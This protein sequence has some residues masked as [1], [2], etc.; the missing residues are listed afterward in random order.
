[1]KKFINQLISK[2]GYN[3]TKISQNQYN[4]F[5]TEFFSILKIAR[6]FSMTSPERMYAAYQATKYIV[7]NNISGDIVECGTWRGGS[8]MIVALTLKLLKSTERK[9]YLYDTY[10]GMSQPT[11]KDVSINQMSAFKNWAK[12][13]NRKEKVFCY[14]P[15]EEV[16]QNVFSTGYPVNN[17]IFVKGKVE[18]TIPS[19][20]PNQIALL[21]L[22]TDWYES[23][24]HEMKHLYPKLISDGVLIIDD[25]GHWQGAREAI[26]QYFTEIN[27][28]PLLNRID[29]TGRL[30]IK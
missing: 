23:T 5:D 8:A 25:Y 7:M 10:E 22:D 21:R 15:L 28:K 3:I 27:R 13:N 26:D 16:Q 1:M 14:S 24:Y 9:I 12:I 18:E 6:P 17:F 19:L 4:D 29:Y 11:E 20:I 30:M 2:A